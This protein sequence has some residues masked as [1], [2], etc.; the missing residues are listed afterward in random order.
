[1][2]ERLSKENLFIGVNVKIVVEMHRELK[3]ALKN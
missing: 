2:M 1:M 3:N